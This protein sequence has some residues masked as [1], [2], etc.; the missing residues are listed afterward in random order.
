MLLIQD[1]VGCPEFNNRQHGRIVVLGC[2]HDILG[3]IVTVG[4]VGISIGIGIGGIL[5]YPFALVTMVVVVLD[6]MRR[7]EQFKKLGIDRHHQFSQLFVD[8]SLQ[9]V[10]NLVGESVIFSHS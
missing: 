1:I 2:F 3:V 9:Y 6:I 4:V 8:C 5:F 10:V 7:R